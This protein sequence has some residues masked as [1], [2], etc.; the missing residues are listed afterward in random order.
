MIA[1]VGPDGV[2]VL[3]AAFLTAL[4]ARLDGVDAR[5]ADVALRAIG[6]GSVRVEHAWLDIDYLR[7]QGPDSEDWRSGFDAMIAYA[8]SKGWISA[9]GATVRA[10]LVQG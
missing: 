10:H 7:R 6:A 3:E 8:R 2:R 9:D 1:V 4:E 5:G